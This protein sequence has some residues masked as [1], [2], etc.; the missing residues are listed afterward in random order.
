M[1]I[2]D[3]ILPNGPAAYCEGVTLTWLEGTTA[4]RVIHAHQESNLDPS[5][6]V[7]DSLVALTDPMRF[8]TRQ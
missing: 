8:I 5:D 2:Q 1:N 7:V 6:L 4:V 3:L